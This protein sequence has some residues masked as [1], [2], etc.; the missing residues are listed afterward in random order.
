MIMRLP[1]FF[2]AAAAADEIEITFFG[3]IRVLVLGMILVFA[4]LN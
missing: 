2:F 1:F 3:E 4:L